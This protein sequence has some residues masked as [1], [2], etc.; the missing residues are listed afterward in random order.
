ML[1]E[2]NVWK[3]AAFVIPGDNEDGYASVSD[4]REG[5]ERLIR[6]AWHRARP[7]EHVAAVHDEIHVSSERRL[8]SRRVVGEE[9]IAAPAPLDPRPNGK[10]EAQVCVGE[11]KDTNDV[12]HGLQ[13]S[14]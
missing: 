10:V 4:T 6:K 14:R 12:G 5:L 8:Q 13:P 3:P 2:A 9:I 11:E 7:V 1:R